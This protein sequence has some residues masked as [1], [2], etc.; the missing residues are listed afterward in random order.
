MQLRPVLRHN[1]P[2]LRYSR[3]TRNENDRGEQHEG[4]LL[5]QG[6]GVYQGE[7]FKTDLSVMED[8]GV[9]ALA[10]PLFDKGFVSVFDRHKEHWTLKRNGI[11]GANTV[12]RDPICSIVKPP[13]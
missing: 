12:H 11:G 2:R 10:P 4:V 3:L 8:G 5:R 6:S 13:E 7:G 1:L 9:T